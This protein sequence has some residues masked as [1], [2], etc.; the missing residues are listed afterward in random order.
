[1]ALIHSDSSAVPNLVP[2]NPNHKLESGSLVG[3]VCK[4]LPIGSIIYNEYILPQSFPISDSTAKRA[5]PATDVILSTSSPADS[6]SHQPQNQS[7]QQQSEMPPPKKRHLQSSSSSSSTPFINNNWSKPTYN[8][9]PQPPKQ[10]F[11]KYQPRPTP[12]KNINN[13]NFHPP[14]NNTFPRHQQPPLHQQPQLRQQ[15]PQLHQ[16]PPQQFHNIPNPYQMPSTSTNPPSPIQ[17]FNNK[18]WQFNFSEGVWYQVPP[19]P[20]PP[21]FNPKQY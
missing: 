17:Y 9:P 2:L 15:P 1:M 12:L 11:Q 7:K 13:K 14:T 8:Y 19:P 21:P 16:Q 5:G 20:P 3:V 18:F 10:P 6:R 4:T